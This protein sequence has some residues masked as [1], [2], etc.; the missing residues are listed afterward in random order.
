[1]QAE[2]RCWGDYFGHDYRLGSP[3]VQQVFELAMQC[4]QPRNFAPFALAN[5]LQTTRFDVEVARR[6]HGDLWRPDWLVRAQDLSTRLT[7]DSVSALREIMRFVTGG[8]RLAEEFTSDLSARL[9]ATEQSIGDE[10]GQLEATIQSTVGRQCRHG[11]PA[12]IALVG[13]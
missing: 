11:R 4:F 6:F 2:K 12:R 9:R 13:S 7:R 5:R 1:M 10:A 3:E 8:R